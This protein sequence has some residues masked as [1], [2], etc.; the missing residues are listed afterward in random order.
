MEEVS[1]ESAVVSSLGSI[2]FGYAQT[3][4]ET[5]TVVI[6]IND[7]S[8]DVAACRNWQGVLIHDLENSP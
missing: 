7:A 3:N 4:V 2:A 8:S 6:C 1:Y 5:L